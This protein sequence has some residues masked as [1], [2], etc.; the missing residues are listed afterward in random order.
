MT[1]KTHAIVLNKINYKESSYIVRVLT[2]SHGVLSLIAKGVRRAKS[3]SLSHFELGNY[4]EILYIK[5]ESNLHIITETSLYQYKDMSNQPYLQLLSSQIALEIMSQLII[6]EEESHDFFNLLLA[7]LDYIP[8]VHNNHLLIIWRFLIKLTYLLG[9]PINLSEIKEWNNYIQTAGEY[10]NKPNILNDRCRLVNTKILD[11]FSI[12]LHVKITC[13][14][15]I[16]Y[17]EFLF[18]N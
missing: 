15:L 10:I 7:Y 14:S 16:L 1:T 2:E 8:K 12:N 17:E 13:K 9:F 3:V 18:S 5:K 6:S 11:W 4:I